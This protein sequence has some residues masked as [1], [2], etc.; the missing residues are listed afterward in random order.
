V[1][2]ASNGGVGEDSHTVTKG[3][4][5]VVH[6]SVEVGVVGETETTT[7]D[8]GTTED[9]VAAI[10]KSDHV[11]HDSLGGLEKLV[12]VYKEGLIVG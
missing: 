4:R 12:Q 11:G 5:R 7:T 1:V 8:L 10:R 9:E 6:D 2:Q 3:L